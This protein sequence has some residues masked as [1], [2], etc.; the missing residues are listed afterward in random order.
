VLARLQSRFGRAPAPNLAA[1]LAAEAAPLIA[2]W[3]S[4]SRRAE[5]TE[6]LDSIAA[7]GELGILH[8]ALDDAT[9]RRHDSESAAA[10]LHEIAAIDAELAAEGQVAAALRAA[11]RHSGQ[12]AAAALSLTVMFV[13]LLALAAS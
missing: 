6:Q 7:T 4:R 1:W 2:T 12:Q 5:L 8:A 11:A 3:K 13:V 9:A 10:A